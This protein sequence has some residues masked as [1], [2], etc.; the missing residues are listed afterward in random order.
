MGMITMDMDTVRTTRRSYLRVVGA[1]VVGSAVVEPGAGVTRQTASGSWPQFG[2]DPGNTSHASDVSEPRDGTAVETP[3]R[4]YTLSEKDT[5]NTR[6]GPVVVGDTMYVT[7][8]TLEGG[9]GEV[10]ALATEDGTERWRR[11]TEGAIW[12]TPAVVDGTVYVTESPGGDPADPPDG[13]VLALD[14]ETGETQWTVTPGGSELSSPV[15]TD[16]LV[17]FATE[18]RRNRQTESSAVVA[19]STSDGTEQWRETEE[20]WVFTTP[21]VADGTLYVGVDPGEFG[22][23]LRAYDVGDWSRQWTAQF[24]WG[25]TTAPTVADGTVY[26]T[27][28]DTLE[29]VGVLRAVDA[30]TGE[31]EWRYETDR[32]LVHSVA[33][34]EGTVVL[35]ADDVLAFEADSGEQRWTYRTEMFPGP[36]TIAGDTVY[37]Q[38]D[39]IYAIDLED[40]TGLWDESTGTAPVAP[41]V[42]G[43]TAYTV[44]YNSALAFSE[45]DLTPTRTPE[46]TT[47]PPTTDTQTTGVPT[48]ETGTPPSG[49]G[50]APPETGTELPGTETS[51]PP[52][53]VTV[54][55][56]RGDGE[57]SATA[58]DEGGGVIGLTR[59]GTSPTGIGFGIGLLGLLFGGGYAAYQR[60]QADDEG[61][62]T[63]DPGDE[64]VGEKSE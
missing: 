59:F 33:V 48:T 62:D 50:T 38:R 63:A 46:P 40:G 26:L 57:G 45:R 19:V 32:N 17:M 54:T 27:A 41:A 56:Q 28:G 44:G 29:D 36:A 34:G 43:E 52:G 12:S 15:V 64:G 8:G 30:D 20:G 5:G 24:E 60:R 1:A 3:W 2:R 39:R 31:S 53:T 35:S 4:I 16:E 14:A 6:A 22:G 13:R 11:E 58:T 9:G 51:A 49:T 25:V 61:D 42:V 37:V 23:Y 10:Y 21:A 18:T 55:R 7:V 47:V